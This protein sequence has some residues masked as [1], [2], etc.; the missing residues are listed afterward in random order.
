MNPVYSGS[1][2]S[3]PPGVSVPLRGKDSHERHARRSS[4]RE[5]GDVSVPLRGKD[6][7]EQEKEWLLDHLFQ[8]DVSVPLR[9]KDSHEHLAN[10][11]ARNVIV[12]FPSPCGEKIVMNAGEVEEA[13]VHQ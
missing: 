5:D 9:G 7:H 13:A 1:G 10:L 2:C 8:S 6:S 11:N 12:P 4:L 3:S